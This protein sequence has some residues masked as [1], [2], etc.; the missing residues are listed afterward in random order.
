MYTSVGLMLREDGASLLTEA[1][2][3]P[4]DAVTVLG[5]RGVRREVGGLQSRGIPGQGLIVLGGIVVKQGL[6]KLAVVLP[7]L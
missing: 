7:E 1:L 4:L 2:Q 5:A 6:L 3:T